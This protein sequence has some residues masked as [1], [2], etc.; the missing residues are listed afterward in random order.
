MLTRRRV[1][2]VRSKLRGDHLHGV[3]GH[4]REG[5]GDRRP[6]RRR[7]RARRWTCCSWPWASVGGARPPARARRRGHGPP[8]DG[9]QHR[10]PT[11]SRA[12][13]ERRAR[14]RGRRVAARQGR[15]PTQVR[16]SAGG[17]CALGHV[18]SG[19]VTRGRCLVCVF[20]RLTAP[21]KCSFPLRFYRTFES[22]GHAAAVGR[23][24]ARRPRLLAPRGPRTA[25]RLRAGL[26]SPI[27]T[28]PAPTMR[29]PLGGE[30][31]HLLSISHNDTQD[32]PG[33]MIL[34]RVQTDHTVLQDQVKQ[35]SPAKP[36]QAKPSQVRQAMPNPT[37]SSQT[38]PS[39]T[40]PSPT[41]TS[42]AQKAKPTQVKSRQTSPG[43]GGQDR[44]GQACL[45]PSQA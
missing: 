9:S 25:A 13:R 12:P 31:R 35:L 19:E 27:I 44:P 3:L 32:S 1:H 33:S 7:A 41:Q 20:L 14:I 23:A 30:M 21:D 5:L 22:C 39:P 24:R 43:Q 28:F 37:K 38:K 26:S 2:P 8:R 40:K 15:G 11:A 6:R 45:K 34:R 17:P 42:P 16:G 36:S 4:H 29:G 10:R 18:A